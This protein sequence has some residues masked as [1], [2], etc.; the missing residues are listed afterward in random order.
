MSPRKPSLKQIVKT[1]RQARHWKEFARK[2]TSVNDVQAA[3]ALVVETSTLA[4]P[5]RSFHTNL[6]YLIVEQKVPESVTIEELIEYFGLLS[7]IIQRAAS[8][9]WRSLREEIWQLLLERAPTQ[10]QE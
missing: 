5:G 10:T 1:G 7:R 4:G 9:K 2:L 6:E 8:P 3:M